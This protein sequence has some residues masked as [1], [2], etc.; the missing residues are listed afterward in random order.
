MSPEK[1]ITLECSGLK[2]EAL[3]AEF[4]GARGA[5]LSHPHPLYGGDMYNS[6]IE[7]ALDAFLSKKISTLRFNFQGVGGSTG[8]FDDGRGEKENVK[9]AVGYL[10]AAGKRR[11]DL[12]GYSF[13]AWVN[14]LCTDCLAEGDAMILVSPPV[15]VM[16]FSRIKGLPCLSLVV[17]GSRDDYAPAA[18]IRGMMPLWNKDAVLDVIEGADHFYYGRLERLREVIGRGIG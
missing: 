10:R 8:F 4:D 5:V 16:D 14:A 3:Y 2:L 13:G 18:L 6:V 1:A 12:L 9:A 7:T 17:T 11:I 15:G